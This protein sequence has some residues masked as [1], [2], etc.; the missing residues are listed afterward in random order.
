VSNPI[1]C[2]ARPQDA[3]EVAAIL[4]EASAWLIGLGIHQWPDPFPLD[5]VEA[6]IDRGE[7]YLAIV[8]SPAAA[9][10][11]LQSEDLLFWGE[12]ESDALYLHRLAVRRAFAGRGLGRTLVEW[13]AA[14]AESSGRKYLRLDC[15]AD[16][17]RIRAYYEALGF[18]HVR[19]R[20][21]PDWKAALYERSLRP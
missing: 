17:P 19:D 20:D 2:T 1:I 8:S 7:V 5:E 15:L 9:T 10:L 4:S 11:T 16:V 3:R 21:L 6:S 12:Q 14:R 18:V 13:A